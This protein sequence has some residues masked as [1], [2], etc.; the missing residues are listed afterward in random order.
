MTAVGGTWR[1]PAAARRRHMITCD[2]HTGH[3]TV[4]LSDLLSRPS[5]LVTSARDT[6]TRKIK[7]GS[8][9]KKAQN[10]FSAV[11]RAGVNYFPQL[12]FQLQLL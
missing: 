10:P 7:A 6:G 3:V 12:Q 9:E 11:T 8:Y 4:T 5:Q 2:G 1:H